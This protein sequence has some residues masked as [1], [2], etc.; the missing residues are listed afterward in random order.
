MPWHAVNYHGQEGSHYSGSK[1]NTIM[2]GLTS[3]LHGNGHK[4]RNQCRSDA[5]LYALLAFPRA[6]SLH[7]VECVK[8]ASMRSSNC[9][10]DW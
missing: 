9:E 2:L 5:V 8:L 6:R 1:R 10:Q 4:A 7:K 3:H